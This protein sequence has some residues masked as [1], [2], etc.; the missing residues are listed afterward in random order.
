MNLIKNYPRHFSH[1]LQN[2][3]KHKLVQRNHY[4]ADRLI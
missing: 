1:N 4:E 3:N 2:I